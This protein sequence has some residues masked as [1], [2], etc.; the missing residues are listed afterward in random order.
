MQSIY[1]CTPW[2][3]RRGELGQSS[4]FYS[5][6]DGTDSAFK[7]ARQVGYSG[8]GFGKPHR[9]PAAWAVWDVRIGSRGIHACSVARNRVWGFDLDQARHPACREPGT[10]GTRSPSV[11]GPSARIW[12]IEDRL[13]IPAA[14]AATVFAL[15]IRRAALSRLVE[16][17]RALGLDADKRI[18]A[19]GAEQQYRPAR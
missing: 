8:N 11:N 16:S 5:D 13:A 18:H 4:I 2:D 6:D 1:E 10:E 17:A 14:S 7:A 19:G 9:F 15:A 3:T 12:V